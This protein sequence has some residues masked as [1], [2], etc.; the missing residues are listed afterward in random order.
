MK[1]VVIGG[2]GLIGRKLVAAL[3]AQDAQVVVAARSRG[4]DVVTGRGLDEALEGAEV[5]IDV[6]SSG[7]GR[8][9]DM[10][11]F[12]R[13]SRS[14]LQVAER[15]AG[16]GHHIVLSAIGVERPGAAGYFEAKLLQERMIGRAGTPFTILRSTPFYEFIYNIVDAGGQ[17]ALIR[18]PPLLMQ[19]VSA[20]DVA[21][22]LLD[23]AMDRPNGAVVEIGG[24]EVHRLDALAESILVA[25]EDPRDLR[26]D[27]EA[28][29]FGASTAGEA[30]TVS[31]GSAL[32][33]IRFDD[34]LR[35]SLAVFDGAMPEAPYG[36]APL[37]Y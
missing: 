23:L 28:P 24:P 25:N 10:L 4:I 26:V 17:G 13:A 14:V 2:T 34:W 11:E 37:A 15:R 19:P 33:S 22:A 9:D 18:L 6:S 29:Y 35:R 27:V 5:V 31:A 1:I 7:Y 20:D 12:F 8:A 30:L 3:S 36:R 21:D 32:A 16:V